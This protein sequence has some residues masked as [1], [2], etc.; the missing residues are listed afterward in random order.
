MEK[1]CIQCGVTLCDKNWLK[2]KKV[3]LSK[4]KACSKKAKSC[5]YKYDTIEL[6][7]LSL[8]VNK[9][10][11]VKIARKNY[12]KKVSLK[13]KERAQNKKDYY[14]IEY[15]PQYKCCNKCNKSKPL[16]KFTL[17]NYS[18]NLKQTKRKAWYK[19]RL[20]NCTQCTMVVMRNQ[21]QNCYVCKILNL[22]V[23][24]T[25]QELIELKRQQ[26]KLYR[27]YHNK[28]NKL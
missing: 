27:E 13:R 25:P 12:I 26:L 11:N 2:P 8:E 28:P 24:E 20:L 6:Q 9:F 5:T 14:Y 10:I 1:C 18:R 4:C 17:M 16:N 22:K 7:K 3:V 23:S 21:L 15:T 19:H